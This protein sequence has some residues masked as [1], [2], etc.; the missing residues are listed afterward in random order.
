MSTINDVATIYKQLKSEWNS[1][2][3]N[4]AKTEQLLSE[5]K[6]NKKN[7]VMFVMICNFHYS[8]N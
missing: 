3:P 1:S 8:W 6:V 7:E 4:L 2:K 5:L